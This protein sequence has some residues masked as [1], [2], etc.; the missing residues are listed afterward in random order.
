MAE[1][2]NPLPLRP[3]PLSDEIVES[4]Q[5]HPVLPSVKPAPDISPA[6]TE[7]PQPAP[8]ETPERHLKGPYRQPITQYQGYWREDKYTWASPRG[9]CAQKKYK[10]EEENG[11]LWTVGRKKIEMT[12]MKSIN[13]YMFAGLP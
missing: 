6:P 11:F 4:R 5:Q 2:F 3:M 7:T 9:T 8:N 13:W 1:Q 12:I 10:G